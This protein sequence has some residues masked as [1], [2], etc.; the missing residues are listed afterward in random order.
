MYVNTCV[1]NLISTIMDTF[2]RFEDLRDYFALS[3]TVYDLTL[4]TVIYVI[5][6][7]T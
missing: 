1:H 5:I 2:R 3:C 4:F 6:K 7:R